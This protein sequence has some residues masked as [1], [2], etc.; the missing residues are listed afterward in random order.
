MKRLALL[1]MFTSMASP[2]WAEGEKPG[3]SQAEPT[4]ASSSA[5]A[6]TILDAWQA[7]Q[8]RI[9]E[10][11][12]AEKILEAWQTRRK[13]MKDPA[14][15]EAAKKDEETPTGPI[16]PDSAAK[17]ASDRDPRFSG[18]YA[19]DLKSDYISYG[20]V[21]QDQGATIQSLLSLRYSLF[22]KVLDGQPESFVNN[23]TGFISTW[24]DFSTDKNLSSPNSSYRN[25]TE[26]DLITGVSFTFADRYNITTLA[27][28]YNSPAG[29]YG[30]GAYLKAELSYNDRGL[31]GK[32]FALLPQ[33]TL[34]Y[35]IPWDS[36]LGLNPDALLVEPGIT[37]S[38]TFG[39]DTTFPVTLGLPMRVGLGNKFY[40]GE[41]YGFFS[42]GPQVTLPINALSKDNVRTFVT[43]GYTY[44][45]LGSTATDF[46][47]NSD[48]GSNKHLFN[49]GVGVTF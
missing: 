35:T 15:A 43:L 17:A 25:F 21:I 36:N 23:I 8:E 20:V 24:A 44:I 1:L 37:P 27:T 29:A 6:V 14:E 4:E 10:P 26:L 48:N 3:V 32:N 13:R 18:I 7:G 12:H 47:L 31:I 9:L 5:Q 42:I 19:L 41:T 45:N 46:I 11:S 33:L 2:V 30:Q 16:L 28:A 39:A 49:L 22:D 38:Y 34:L 40:D